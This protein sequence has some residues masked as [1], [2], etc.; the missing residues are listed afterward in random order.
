MVSICPFKRVTRKS[1]IYLIIYPFYKI[2]GLKLNL[3]KLKLLFQWFFLEI[4]YEK[5]SL[6]TSVGHLR[7]FYLMS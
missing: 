1:V 7:S 2:Q 4:L 5:T 3:Q 6:I